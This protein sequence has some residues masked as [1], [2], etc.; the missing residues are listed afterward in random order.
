MNQHI[1]LNPVA[2]LVPC[3][4]IDHQSQLQLRL[5]GQPD[6][7]GGRGSGVHVQDGS[8]IPF[9]GI[10]PREIARRYQGDE[11]RHGSNH[12]HEEIDE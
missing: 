7:G 12:E 8:G 1:E 9:D 10:V 5:L 3:L 11:S 2:R 4:W 6:P